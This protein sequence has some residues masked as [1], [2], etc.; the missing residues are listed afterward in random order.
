MQKC[1]KKRCYSCIF[2]DDKTAF[3]LPP[4][5]MAEIQGY[6]IKGTNHVCHYTNLVCRGGR[7]YQAEIW[8][9]LGILEEPTVECLEK[10]LELHNQNKKS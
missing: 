6:L 4:A 9:R 8:H 2:N 5:R 7:E 10:N 1:N 3:R